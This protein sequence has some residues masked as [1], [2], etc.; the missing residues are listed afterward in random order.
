[1]FFSLN[2]FL[3]FPFLM[4]K[5]LEEPYFLNTYPELSKLLEDV[6]KNK[7]FHGLKTENFPDKL[8][9][10]RKELVKNKEK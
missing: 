8:K 1:M 4:W 5:F 3:L 7:L 10:I 9:I 6:T 2:I